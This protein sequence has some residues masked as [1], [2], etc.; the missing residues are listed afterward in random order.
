MHGVVVDCDPLDGDTVVLDVGGAFVGV[1]ELEL[2]DANATD[3]APINNTYVRD[4]TFLL[5]ILDILVELRQRCIPG[6]GPKD[7][8]DRARSR[9]DPQRFTRC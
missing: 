8:T 3:D 2:Q 6:L 1:F 4:N 9:R 7:D 5:M